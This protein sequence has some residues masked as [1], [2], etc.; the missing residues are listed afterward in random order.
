MRDAPESGIVLIFDNKGELLKSSTDQGN[1]AYF[2]FLKNYE[3]SVVLALTQDMENHGFRR[4][5]GYIFYDPDTDS[6]S[7]D[8]FSDS[9]THSLSF[10]IPMI[11]FFIFAI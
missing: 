2:Q 10:I 4:N 3:K 9:F 7:T 8:T 5:I 1:F 6:N 11:V